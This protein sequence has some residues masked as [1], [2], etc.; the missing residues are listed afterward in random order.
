MNELS[1]GKLDTVVSVVFTSRVRILSDPSIK[2]AGVVCVEQTIN[3]TG[4]QR[5]K[6][7][8]TVR[9]AGV[10]SKSRLIF[11]SQ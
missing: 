7:R 8:R 1:V 2:N 5:V 3:G 10:E 6:T 9:E 11:S 4:P